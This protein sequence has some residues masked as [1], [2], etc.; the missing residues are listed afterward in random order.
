LRRSSPTADPEFVDGILRSQPLDL[1]QVPSN[2]QAQRLAKIRMAK[3]NPRWSGSVRTNFAGLDALGE[4]AVNL[5]FDEL[6][7]PDGT[8]D[9]PF[10]V[11]GKIGFLPDRT[12][13]TVSLSS[14][15]PACYDWNV[16]EEQAAPPRPEDPLP[17]LGGGALLEGETTG[18]AVDFTYPTDANRVAVK[19]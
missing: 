19:T 8:F 10:L 3:V 9:G 2:S 11:N 13:M 15:D 12:G 1:T 7:Q 16:T 17:A 18:F 4:A 5:S 14:I 6:D